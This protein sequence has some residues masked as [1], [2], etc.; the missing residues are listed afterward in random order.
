M[1]IIIG[2][3]TR[4]CSFSNDMNPDSHETSAFSDRVVKFED[5]THALCDYLL[6]SVFVYIN[7]NKKKKIAL[8]I[9]DMGFFLSFVNIVF[10]VGNKKESF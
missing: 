2:V 5:W 7:K 8:R 1:E 9:E 3:C 10:S 6:D 4:N